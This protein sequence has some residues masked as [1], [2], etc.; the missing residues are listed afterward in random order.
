MIPAEAVERTREQGLEQ[1]KNPVQRV[2]TAIKSIVGV[3]RVHEPLGRSLHARRFSL[4]R[5]HQFLAIAMCN[6][7]RHRSDRG[8]SEADQGFSAALHQGH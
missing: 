2:G 8:D 5:P 6:Y 1:A 4:W 3:F 7:L